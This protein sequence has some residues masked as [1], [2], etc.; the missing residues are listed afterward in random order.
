[1]DT[2]VHLGRGLLG[3]G[4]LVLVAW[5]LSADRRAIVWRNVATGIALQFILAGLVLHFSP[6]RAAVEWVG[7]RFVDLLDF[8]NAGVGLLFG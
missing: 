2:L 8:T 5:L 4:A 3:I 7:A 6:A 1:M